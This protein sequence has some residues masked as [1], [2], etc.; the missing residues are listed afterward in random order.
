M[1]FLKTLF[2]PKH[3]IE[4]YGDCLTSAPMSQI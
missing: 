1:D 4:Q 3:T 2:S